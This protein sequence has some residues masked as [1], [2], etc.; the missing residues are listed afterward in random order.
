[1]M[2]LSLSGSL[3]PGSF[4]DNL[5]KYN[6]GWQIG[7]RKLS[8]YC[9]QWQWNTRISEQRNLS[10]IVPGI[11]TNGYITPDDGLRTRGAFNRLCFFLA[12]GVRRMNASAKLKR[13]ELA[14]FFFV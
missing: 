7:A 10:H 2:G 4:V 8:T 1:M 11:V 9:D 14:A 6:L 13:S 3:T 5:R 12:S